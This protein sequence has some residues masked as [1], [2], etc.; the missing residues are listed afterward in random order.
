M[1]C[2]GQSLFKFSVFAHFCIWVDTQITEVPEAPLHEYQYAMFFSA[3]CAYI[4]LICTTSNKLSIFR[5]YLFFFARYFRFRPLLYFAQ[6]KWVAATIQGQRYSLCYFM[7]KQ[8]LILAANM[9]VKIVVNLSNFT[10]QRIDDSRHYALLRIL[11]W[12]HYRFDTVFDG[13]I[14]TPW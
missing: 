8:I 10:I 2:G 5:V 9:A 13:E 11:R 1:I 14:L 4:S 3:C 12:A 6:H 7:R